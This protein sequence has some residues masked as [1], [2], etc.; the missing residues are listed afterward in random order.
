[1]I[2]KYTEKYL[3]VIQENLRCPLDWVNKNEDNIFLQKWYYTVADFLP[4]G[5][6]DAYLLKGI[7]GY[8]FEPNEEVLAFELNEEEM[9]MLYH[10]TMAYKDDY[11]RAYNDS[12]LKYFNI[13]PQTSTERNKH[14]ALS[15]KSISELV[16]RSRN[17]SMVGLL[18]PNFTP[19]IQIDFFWIAMYDI[20][21]RII[22]DHGAINKNLTDRDLFDIAWEKLLNQEQFRIS[23]DVLSTIGYYAG[24]EARWLVYDT[25]LSGGITHC[26]PALEPLSNSFEAILDD[27]QG[28]KEAFI[29]RRI[30]WP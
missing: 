19:S 7:D 12:C 15:V 14:Y 21:E 27:L 13:K 26:Y 1:M 11:R 28:I 10:N 3:R 24:K 17:N 30:D 22:F 6:V 20:F 5:E 16:E 25:S 8:L 2:S 4:N 23:V 29:E 9:M 18:L